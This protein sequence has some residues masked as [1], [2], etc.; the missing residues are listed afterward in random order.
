MKE[1][2]IRKNGTIGRITL[3][4][5]KALNSLTYNML[6]EIEKALELW[7]EDKSVTAVVID[8]IGDKAFCAGGDIQEIYKNGVKKNYK[9]AQKF[10]SDEYRINLKIAEYKKPYISFMQGFTMGGGIGISCHGSHRVVGE[11]S[12]LAMPECSIGLVPDVGGSFLLSRLKNNLGV[13]LGITGTRMNASD[14]IFCRFAD[15]YIPTNHWK[16]VINL[17]IEGTDILVALNTFR[18][19]PQ[20]SYLNEQIDSISEALDQITFKDIENNLS[21]KNNLQKGFENLRKNSPLSVAFTFSMLQLP[22]VGTDLRTALDFE[23]RYT[24][25]AQEHTDF[26][27]GIRALVIDKDRSP[28]W[29]HSSIKDV[30]FEEID[31]LL[32]PL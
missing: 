18:E 14:A 19:Q 3:Q 30:T 21:R 5:P 11:T 26:L 28:K 12:I 9:F 1:I 31:M 16:N 17:M 2:N 8:A 10:W 25:R 23:Y 13:Y 22:K 6:I 15:F 4:R 24:Y 27:E 32:K 20:K 29:K 7:E